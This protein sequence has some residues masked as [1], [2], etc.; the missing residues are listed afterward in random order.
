ME[1]AS[2]A[3]KHAAPISEGFN[4]SVRAKSAAPKRLGRIQQDEEVQAQLDHIRMKLEKAHAKKL[5]EHQKMKEQLQRGSRS[6]VRAS[7][8]DDYL[9]RA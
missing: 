1:A 6:E 7:R 5:A 4:S 9:I 3:P 8:E 2:P